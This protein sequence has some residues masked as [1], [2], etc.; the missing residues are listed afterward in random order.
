MK[1]I[2]HLCII[3]ILSLAAISCTKSDLS[4]LTAEQPVD[5]NTDPFIYSKIERNI[6]EPFEVQ[7]GT[8]DA[9]FQEGEKVTIFL[10]YSI[11][12]ETFSTAK[13]T[14]TDDATGLP[15]NTYDLLSYNDASASQL[16]LPASLSDHKQPFFFISFIADEGYAGKTVSITT[17]LEGQA[18]NS[19]DVV[20]A[21]FSV[22]P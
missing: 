11:A 19:T 15:I 10:P 9:V 13:V 3:A 14:M 1:T 8:P 5:T 6:V 2:F 17:T 12:N 18:T 7:L 20:N 21:A 4:R 22:V 16:A